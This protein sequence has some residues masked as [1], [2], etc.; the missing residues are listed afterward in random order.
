MSDTSRAPAAGSM[1]RPEMLLGQ[2]R[3]LPLF[4]VQALGAFNDNV[5]KTAF[6]TLLTF[7]LSAQLEMSNDALNAIAGGIFILPFALFAPVAGQIADRVDKAAMMRVVK[8]A[9]IVLMVGAAIA[10]HVQGVVLLYV[11]LFL[12]GAQSAF[13]SPIK[14]GVLPQYLRPHELVRGNGLIQA[15]TFF[16]ILL[17]TIVG[18]NLVLTERGVLLVSIAVVAVA[19]IGFIASLRAPP[20]PP[21]GE[22]GAPGARWSGLK[23][24]TVERV[25]VT[26]PAFL[27][28]WLAGL[29]AAHFVTDGVSSTGFWLVAL[30]LTAVVAVM[31]LLWP[32]IE[33][34]IQSGRSVTRAWRA[35]LS[36]AW[37]WGVGM[38]YLT[39]LPVLTKDVLG[40]DEGV[41]TVLLAA[42]SIGVAIGSVMCGFIYRGDVK[43]GVAPW[44]AVGI[45]LFSI[46][47]Q[48]AIGGEVGPAG[49]F[50]MN[51]RDFFSET[52]GWRVFIDF[53]GLAIC[54]G[55][56][57][58]P[59]NALYQRAAPEEARG[60]IV[61]S[62][63]LI[64]STMM[65]LAVVIILALASQGLQAHEILTIF[66]ATGLIAAFF[67]ARRAPETWLGRMALSVLPAGPEN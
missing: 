20:A 37:F 34:S 42:F 25:R 19:I 59:L 17:G 64:D 63:N 29:V 38:A 6:V 23:A 60:R 28:L 35:I 13:F 27:A 12:M 54:A 49:E 66:G 43:V 61:A 48:F 53:I 16:A 2:R 56:Y 7:R 51:W 46:D 45:A 55:V 26:R 31:L 15:A 11:I 30:A 10:Y 47:L 57:L 44:G 58:T 33:D 40:A 62:S 41:L 67:V 50:L 24:R 65:A 36:I 52:R 32:S 8:F 14:Y 18:A 22:Q 39:L 5:F 1:A 4:L 9:E 21:Y 3:F